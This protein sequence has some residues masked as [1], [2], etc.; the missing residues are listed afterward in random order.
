MQEKG[1]CPFVITVGMVG[2]ALQRISLM[3]SAERRK[4]EA[5]LL[6]KISSLKRN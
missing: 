2:A 5:A 6:F 3:K 1:Q 4:Y